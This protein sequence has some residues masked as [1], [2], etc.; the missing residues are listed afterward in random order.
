MKF[1]GAAAFMQYLFDRPATAR[2]AAAIVDA[3]LGGRPSRQPPTGV[4]V[5]GYGLAIPACELFATSFSD[6]CFPL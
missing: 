3:I 5:R 6:A 2:P 4:A 1:I